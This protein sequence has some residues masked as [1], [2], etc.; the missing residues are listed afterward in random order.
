ML[1]CKNGG[2]IPLCDLSIMA[3]FKIYAAQIAEISQGWVWLP[4]SI[5]SQRSIVKL[6]S[7]DTRKTVYCEA[8]S[9]DDNF[10]CSYNESQRTLE[11][12]EPRSALVAS[13]WYRKR[14]GICTCTEAE[15]VVTPSNC[16]Y[17]QI[18]ACLDHPQIV[19][20]LAVMLALW[21]VVLSFVFGF[22]SI[23]LGIV[24]LYCSH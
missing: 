6:F 7:K 19:V 16:G 23:G 3:L 9:I 21:S 12:T 24:S 8:L 22:I 1:F 10:V 4:K 20:R 15:I 17:W 2:N 5:I 13:E 14:L 11:I 18:R